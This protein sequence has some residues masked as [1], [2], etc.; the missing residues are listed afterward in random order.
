MIMLVELYVSGVSNMTE[1]FGEKSPKC[2]P[3]GTRLSPLGSYMSG[4]LT[5]GAYSMI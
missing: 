4:M 2:C 5:P 3:S 1:D